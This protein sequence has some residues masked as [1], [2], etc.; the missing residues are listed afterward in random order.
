MPLTTASN[1]VGTTLKPSVSGVVL[2]PKAAVAP[3]SKWTRALV[4]PGL[5][6]PWSVALDEVG[7]LAASV[8]TSLGANASAKSFCEPGAPAVKRKNGVPIAPPWQAAPSALVGFAVHVEEIGA[9]CGLSTSANVDAAMPPG[10]SSL[11]RGAAAPPSK[12]PTKVRRRPSIS[13]CH[14]MYGTL[15]ANVMSGRLALLA[16]FEMAWPGWKGSK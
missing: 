9:R 3:K 13:S 7:S 11:K 16:L 10:V 8:W 12:W 2:D 14:E 15:P 6:E 1:V 5:A 4:P